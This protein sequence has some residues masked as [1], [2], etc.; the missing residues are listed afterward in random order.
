MSLNFVLFEMTCVLKVHKFVNQVIYAINH[1]LG[2]AQ[3]KNFLKMHITD[4][5]SLSGFFAGNM[6]VLY[7][8][9]PK[10]IQ[11]DLGWVMDIIAIAVENYDC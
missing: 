7:L 6:S 2:W 5:F 1:Y 10:K 4:T 11:K 9:N 8:D 3:S